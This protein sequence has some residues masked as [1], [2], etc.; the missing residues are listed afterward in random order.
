MAFR[1]NVLSAMTMVLTGIPGVAAAQA[2]ISLE[3]G[4]SQNAGSNSQAGSDAHAT[5]NSNADVIN[6]SSSANT[7]TT[8]I[9]NNATATATSNG[10]L[11]NSIDNSQ[12]SSSHTIIMAIQDL[13]TVTTNSGVSVEGSATQSTPAIRTGDNVVSGA[14]FANFAGVLNNGWNSGLASNALAATNIA[15]QGNTTVGRGN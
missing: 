15:A 7:V 5:G 10:V 13:S 1:F 14:S 3:A 8:D 2:P 9:G 11:D 6:Q 12:D 4:I